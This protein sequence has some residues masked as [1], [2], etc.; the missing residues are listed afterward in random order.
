MRRRVWTLSAVAVAA[1]GLTGYLL[2]NS[3]PDQEPPLAMPSAVV[4]VKPRLPQPAQVAGAPELPITQVVLYS[5][6]VGYFQRD[7]QVD[8]NARI[9]LSF[10]VQDV[11]DLL[12]SMVL[13]DLGGGQ[14]SAVSYDS[15]DPL[16]KTLSSFAIR[17]ADNPTHA[18]ILTQARGEHVQVT[19]EK[20]LHG[21]EI[22]QGTI[23]GVETKAPPTKDGTAVEMLNLWCADGMRNVP[24]AEVQCVK[25]LNSAVDS[26]VRR[27]LEVLASSHDSQKKSVS[28]QFSGSGKRD[29]RVGYVV[30]TP[31]WRTSYRLLVDKQGKVF[32]QG[33]AL[34]ENPSSEDWKDVQMALVSARPISFK[35]D[36]YQPLYA[37]RP[38]VQNQVQTAIGPTAHEENVTG[39]SATFRNGQFV[40]NGVPID[41]AWAAGGSAA[42]R[43]PEMLGDAV[44]RPMAAPASPAPP[45][46][47]A[48]RASPQ[49]N[50]QNGVMATAKATDLGNSFQYAIEQPVTIPRQ[51]SALL[52]FVNQAIEGD[53]ISIYSPQAH[54]K[55]A[56]SALRL[57]NS[58]GFHLMQGP[59][60]VFEGSGY[61]G[62][63]QL[64]DLPPKAERLISYAV[65]LGI[66]VEVKPGKTTSQ[67]AAIRLHN[68][69]LTS[70]EL[71][72]DSITYTV[73]NRS[74]SDRTVLVEHPR[75]A[76]FRLCS[77]DKPR[78]EAADVYRFEKKLDAGKTVS[79]KVVEENDVK[80]DNFLV[81]L[82]AETVRWYLQC[83]FEDAKAKAAFEKLQTLHG[84]IIAT[85]E[86]RARV[87]QQ[88]DDIKADQDRLRANL[89]EMPATSAAY[90]RYLEKFDKQETTIE[91][92]Q[93]RIQELQT[94]A[95]QQQHDCEVYLNSLDFETTICQTTKTPVRNLLDESEDMRQKQAEWRR[96]WMNNQPSGQPYIER[97]E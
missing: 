24:L 4:K 93:E 66:E 68:G 9:D 51:K 40:N 75:R 27:A 63:A 57:K 56:L 35:M 36:L 67:L 74:N 60:A 78:E 30:E 43:S 88:L 90:K 52:P 6:G 22:V 65:D 48:T 12:K 21:Q 84:K 14:V 71:I 25:F 81:Q 91:K 37:P 76:E 32:L 29:V 80:R 3:P 72:R 70:T 39:S 16:D 15:H 41:Q 64:P 10:P 19:V 69:M 45:P 58:S 77:K 44:P 89:K 55:Y 92:L 87:K 73:R 20:A 18:M 11:N 96:F 49:I 33:W 26:E 79:F 59:V 85:N 53:K 28:L 23:V 61:A 1:V 5:N 17:L 31:L 94:Q 46:V 42:P 7:G 86:D 34:V 50:L 97:K 54:T 2:A 8:G 13:Q 62:D 47:S 95:Q 83:E 38:L 82:S